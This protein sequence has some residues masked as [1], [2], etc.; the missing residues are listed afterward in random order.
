MTVT[1]SGMA[2]TAF[3]AVFKALKTL[4]P[5][6][7]IHPSGVA[8]TGT[9][10]KRLGNTGSG[11]LWVD[12]PGSHQVK[13]RLSRSV[14]APSGWPDII[15]LALRITSEAG[16]ADVLLAS[17][18]MSWP[19]RL[20]LTP[21]RHASNSKLTSLMPYKGA[22]GPVLLAART[23]QPGP[24][25]P[26][27]PDAFRQALNTGTWT[28]GLYHAR[29]AGPWIRF[30]SLALTLDPDKA[31]TPTRFDPLTHT[32]PGAETYKWASRLREPSYA[33][34]REPVR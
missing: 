20:L 18:P 19:G 25:L 8:L 10:E 26:A 29:P 22:K 1:L 16:P 21:H 31:D 13:A 33:T 2:G 4:R 23:D 34:A 15:G 30:G 12:S 28:L 24:C 14:G 6:R 5:D 3:A 17:T 32:L 9:I 27:T 7:P 11:I